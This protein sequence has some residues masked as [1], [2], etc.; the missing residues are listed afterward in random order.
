[1]T[2]TM[3]S[4]KINDKTVGKIESYA[5]EK[6]ISR[7]QAVEELTRKAL[8]VEEG[9][10]IVL[11]TDGGKNI[12]KTIT[13][14]TKQETEK[15]ETQISEISSNTRTQMLGLAS[16]FIWLLVYYESVLA[17]GFTVVLGIAVIIIN[18][19]PL[20]RSWSQ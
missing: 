4:A 3:V 8:T 19:V 5:E 12:E 7:S 14:A 15:L 9:D 13:Q 18:L 2:K 20:V 1:M 11:S 6:D 10:G 16:A 17:T